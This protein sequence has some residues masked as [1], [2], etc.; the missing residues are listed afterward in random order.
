MRAS[1]REKEVLLQEIHHRVKNNLQIISSLLHL[2]SGHVVDRRAQEVFKESQ[3]RI[4]SMALVHERLYS[5]HD[6]GKISFPEYARNLANHL[7][8]SYGINSDAIE[9][10]I[11]AEDVA[12]SIDT[13][14][15]CGL[16]L[17]ELLS[18]CLLHAF[19]AGHG[20]VGIDFYSEGDNKLTLAV[21]DN[22]VGLPSTMDYRQAKSLGWQL[23]NAL[24]GQLGATIDVQSHRG[25]VVQIIFEAQRPKRGDEHHVEC[26]DPGS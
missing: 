19:P 10:E 22:G 14:V 17:N 2:Q 12:L 5:A 26:T 13:A 6:L 8:R 25:T 16:I 3:N 21:R 15:P 9:L 4:Q 1:L 11:V 18:N 7:F 23:I 20:R 24:A